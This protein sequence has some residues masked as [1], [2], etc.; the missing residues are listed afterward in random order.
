SFQYGGGRLKGD[1]SEFTEEDFWKVSDAML[2]HVGYRP[3]FISVITEENQHKALDNVRLAKRMSEGVP[4][5]KDAMGRKVG[6]E[7]K[8]NYAMASGPVVTDP[9]TG[10]QMGQEGRPYQLSKIYEIYVQVHKE[11][12]TDWEFN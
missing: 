9:R 6:V 2:E 8:L 11:G 5:G 4:A 3:D 7:C 1:L 12:L 10:H